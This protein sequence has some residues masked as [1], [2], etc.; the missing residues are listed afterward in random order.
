MVRALLEAEDEAHPLPFVGS[1]AMRD[2]AT[3]VLASI[4]QVLGLDRSSSGTGSPRTDTLR[5]DF[6]ST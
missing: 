6:L 1:M 2:G 5:K 3:A 4:M